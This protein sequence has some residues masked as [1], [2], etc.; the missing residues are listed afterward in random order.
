MGFDSGV[1]MMDELSGVETIPRETTDHGNGSAARRGMD[2]GLG[3][4]IELENVFGVKRP[5]PLRILLYSPF[6][7]YGSEFCCPPA[8]LLAG[9]AYY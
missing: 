1:E 5:D 3:T 6:V 7:C 4:D 9:T 2:L 8:C